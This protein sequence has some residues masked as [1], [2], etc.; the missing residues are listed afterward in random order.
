MVLQSV[1]K[2]KELIPDVK[3][4]IMFYNDGMVYNSTFEKDVNI[5]KLGLNLAEILNHFKQL[6]EI[7]NFEKEPYKKIIYET[8]SLVIGFLKLGENSNVALIIDK[9]EDKT[10]KFKPIRRCL[11]HIEKLIDM[12]KLELDKNKLEIKKEELEKLKADL[13]E[14]N[15]K[16][17]KIKA[18][19]ENL[20][21]ILEKKKEDLKPKKEEIEKIMEIKAKREADLK[22]RKENLKN[23]EE[24]L[25]ETEKVDI[26]KEEEDFN[27]FCKDMEEQVTD[28]SKFE[29]RIFKDEEEKEKMRESAKNFESECE[30]L[31]YTIL[32]KIDDLAKLEEDISIRDKEKFEEKI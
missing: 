28:L 14:K 5:P 30:N 22:L 17:D 21:T 18:D 16:I 24:E 19:I 29:N 10:I 7:C 27:N 8:R 4:V 1:K 9:V 6:S 25:K 3:H 13:I 26:K 12:D 23:L 2:I 32:N 20:E 15:E 31:K 11:N